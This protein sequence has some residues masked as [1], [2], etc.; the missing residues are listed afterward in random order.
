MASLKFCPQILAK[1]ELSSDLHLAALC[2]HIDIVKGLVNK[3]ADVNVKDKIFDYTPLFL[4]ACSGSIEIVKWL[5]NRELQKDRN[6][7]MEPREYKELL[8]HTAKC[9]SIEIVKWLIDG[10]LQKDR[11]Y[12]MKDDEYKR[13]VNLAVERGDIAI[14]NHISYSKLLF[15]VYSYVNPVPSSLEDI[16]CEP[17]LRIR[18][19]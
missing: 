4:A 14:A 7:M 9:G 12:K 8:Y 2:G 11:N 5:I 6:Y 15:P 10:E 18:S 17:Q 3:G 13:L 19:Q 16:A 1:K